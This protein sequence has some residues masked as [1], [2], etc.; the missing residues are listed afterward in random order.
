M[1]KYNKNDVV[2]IINI[3]KDKKIINFETITDEIINQFKNYGSI[4]NNIV[5]T[6]DN[7]TYISYSSDSMGG[8]NL[9]ENVIVINL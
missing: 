4:H 9:K 6:E 3:L 7:N 5:I 2:R 1:V 8:R